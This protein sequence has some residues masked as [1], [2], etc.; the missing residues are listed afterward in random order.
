M[1][2]AFLPWREF[3]GARESQLN[4]NNQT[5]HRLFSCL[6]QPD[7]AV[8]S[9]YESVKKEVSVSVKTSSRFFS[10]RAKMAHLRRL[11]TW[12]DQSSSATSPSG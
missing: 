7:L 10:V 9:R 12:S 3:R 11:A 5:Q 1:V 2:Q 8:I 4:S 6:V